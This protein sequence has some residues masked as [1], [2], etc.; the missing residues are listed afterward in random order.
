MRDRARQLRA[1]AT[2]FEQNLWQQLRAGRFSGFK[3]RRQQVLDHYIVDFACM[4]AK[5]IV[6]L[7]GS[8]HAAAA[9]Y[10]A[11]MLG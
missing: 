7:D 10:D 3:F 4:Q 2:P 5:V 9:V 11:E 1:D 6:E 8:Q